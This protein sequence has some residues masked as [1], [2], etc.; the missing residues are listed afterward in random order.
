M[1]ESRL[2]LLDSKKYLNLVTEHRGGRLIGKIC[3]VIGLVVEASGIRPFIGEI[4]RIETAPGGSVP[5][6][7]VGF[8]AD[9]CLLMP[10]GELKGVSPGCRVFPTGKALCGWGKP[11][12]SVSMA[13]AGI[14]PREKRRLPPVR[15]RNVRFTGVRQT[16]WSGRRLA[17]S[18]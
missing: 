4:C 16:P 13:L 2:P 3:Q 10:Y 18:C 5:A 14:W 9:R 8:R 17:I 15:G 7:V 12:G 11:F 1:S 6:E